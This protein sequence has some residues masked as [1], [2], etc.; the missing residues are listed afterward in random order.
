MEKHYAVVGVMEEFYLS[1][2]VM[3]KFVPKF[4]QGA[5]EVYTNM[6]RRLG[7]VNRNI[8][9]P[10]VDEKIKELVRKNMTREVD[11]YNFCRQRLY[12]QYLLI[13]DDLSE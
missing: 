10:K 7:A 13:K 5:P 11:F 9:Q 6:K 12:I 3:E 8:Y 2:Q 1:M 4:F